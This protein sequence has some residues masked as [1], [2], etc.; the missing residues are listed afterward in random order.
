ML[1]DTL[2][3]TRPLL[4]LIHAVMLLFTNH[5]EDA[6][7]FLQDAEAAIRSDVPADQKRILRGQIATVRANVLYYY[8]DVVQSVA[9]ARQCLSNKW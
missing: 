1:P 6:E 4:C 2:V 9:L 3:R 5:L 7:T 8:S